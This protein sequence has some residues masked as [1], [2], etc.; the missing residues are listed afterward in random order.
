MSLDWIYLGTISNLD[1]IS[2]RYRAGLSIGPGHIFLIF[3]YKV[4]IYEF[5]LEKIVH[6]F[7][8]FI[9]LFTEPK[10]QH[11]IQIFVIT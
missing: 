3:H 7:L 8:T 2:Y 1:E 10:T 5:I 11:K 6:R 9:V 4:D